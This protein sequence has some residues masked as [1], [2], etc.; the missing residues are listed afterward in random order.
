MAVIGRCDWSIGA[1]VAGDWD[2]WGYWIK[3]LIRMDERNS[4]SSLWKIRIKNNI[5]LHDI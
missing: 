5:W 4:G 3:N 1:G 2:N